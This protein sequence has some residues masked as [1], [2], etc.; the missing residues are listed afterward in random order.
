[1]TNDILSRVIHN[2]LHHQIRQFK[3]QSIHPARVGAS[4]SRE[5]FHISPRKHRRTPL[6][7]KTHPR[8]TDFAGNP[9]LL[10][11]IDREAE[12]ILLQS[13]FWSFQPFRRYLPIKGNDARAIQI[14]RRLELRKLPVAHLAAVSRIHPIETVAGLAEPRYLREAKG[15]P[16]VIHRD[17]DR[18]FS[19]QN[20]LAIRKRGIVGFQRFP[21]G[22]P[23]VNHHSQRQRLTGADLVVHLNRN[24]VNP[25]LPPRETGGFRESQQ[26]VI[27][28]EA[29]RAVRRKQNRYRKRR[30][31]QVRQ[32]LIPNAETQLHLLIV[33]ETA[34]GIRQILHHQIRQPHDLDIRIDREK[35]VVL[36]VEFRLV[37]VD[38]QRQIIIP[39]RSRRWD[40]QIRLVN[41]PVI[42]AEI[43]KL[44]QIPQNDRARGERLHRILAH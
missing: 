13:T 27:V 4:A 39:G 35:V 14:H 44:L 3:I 22:V 5:I 43:R 25:F 11:A 7:R 21:N 42:R 20:I 18:Q 37:A 16:V 29:E 34:A 40:R 32:S 15:L 19:H 31:R 33:N 28:H 26:L 12:K 2:I 9:R 1:M 36:L 38:H 10:D 30:R 41:K 8:P 23:A 6:Q 24:I 17:V